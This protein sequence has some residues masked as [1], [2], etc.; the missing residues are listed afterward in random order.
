MI[1]FAIKI[2]APTSQKIEMCEKNIQW[3]E[4]SKLTFLSHRLK[5]RLAY[6]LYCVIIISLLSILEQAIQTSINIM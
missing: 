3:C 5:S 4:E 6:L 1:E 2:D